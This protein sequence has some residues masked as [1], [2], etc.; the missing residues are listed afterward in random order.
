M[1]SAVQSA[2]A[3]LLIA[4]S[5]KF[6]VDSSEFTETVSELEKLVFGF[7]LVMSHGVQGY[8][9][10]LASVANDL[11][12]SDVEESTVENIFNSRNDRYKGYKSKELGINK[13]I[14][15]IREKKKNR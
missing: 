13:C 1:H 15:R 10:M 9:T 12:W 14:E 7:S 6:G 5:E 4:V 11:Y 8:R 3:P 2:T